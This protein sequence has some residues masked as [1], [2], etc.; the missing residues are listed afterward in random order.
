MLTAAQV[1]ALA[2]LVGLV[3]HDKTPITVGQD[4]AYSEVAVS[5]GARLWLIDEAGRSTRLLP[6][7][8]ETT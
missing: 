5:C 4:P 7:V 2:G 3:G 6:L 1:K 8:G